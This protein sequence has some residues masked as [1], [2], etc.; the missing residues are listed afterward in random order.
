MS[1]E[2]DLDEDVLLPGADSLIPAPVARSRGPVELVVR[3]KAEGMRLDHYLHMY[4]Q[5]FSRSELQEAVKGG[6]ILVNGKPSK[7]SYKV[8]NDD[9]LFVV[10][11]EPTHDLPQPEDIP[12]EVLYEDESVALINK[13]WNMVVHPAKGNWSGTLD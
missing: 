1:T 12:L 8:R 9:K 13:P 5:D 3:I 6:T 11:P 10:L 2:P 7:A 4:F